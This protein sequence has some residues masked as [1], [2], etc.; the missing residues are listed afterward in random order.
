MD[1]VLSKRSSLTFTLKEDELRVEVEILRNYA[2]FEK[3][4]GLM[5][6]FGKSDLDRAMKKHRQQEMLEIFFMYIC[7]K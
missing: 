7:C 1:L 5:E 6:R 4:R 3:N 2:S